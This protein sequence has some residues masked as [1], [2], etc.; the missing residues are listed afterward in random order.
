MASNISPLRSANLLSPRPLTT[1]LRL[2]PSLILVSLFLLCRGPSAAAQ[3]ADSTSA[4]C[5]SVPDSEVITRHAIRNAGLARL[6]DLFHLADRWHTASIDGYTWDAQASGLAPL[7]NPRWT[8]LVDDVPAEIALFGTQSLDA[9]PI[10]INEV[11]CIELIARPHVAAGK[12]QQS[13]SLRILTR[14]PEAGMTLGASVAAGN[15]VNDPGPFAYTPSASP[16]IDRIGP[17][18]TGIIELRSRGRFVRLSGK[19]DEFHVT[20]QQ[21]DLRARQLYSLDSKPRIYTQAFALSAGMETR[22]GTQKI[23]AGRSETDD[24]LFFETFGVEIPAKRRVDMLATSGSLRLRGGE[25][26]YRGSFTS[27]ELLERPNATGINLDFQKRV[28]SAGL[29]SRLGSGPIRTTIG[30]SVDVVDA[31]TSQA[32]QDD[33]TT[34]T[35][36]Y[37]LAEASLADRFHASV[38]GSWIQV[39]DEP[40]VSVMPSVRLMLPGDRWIAASA[41]LARRTLS[42]DPSLWRWTH[43]GYI[44]PDPPSNDDGIRPSGPSA[45]TVANLRRPATPELFTADAEFGGRMPEGVDYLVGAY[46]R[47]SFTDYLADHHIDYSEESTGFLTRTR[48]FDDVSGEIIG[49]HTRLSLSL[50]PGFTQRFT[51]VAE[52]AIAGDSLFERAHARV[53]SQRFA[54]TATFSPNDRFSLWARAR[55]QPSTVWSEYEAASVSSGGF[56]VSELA[57]RVLLDVAATKRLWRDHLA[58]TLSIRNL[59]NEPYRAHPAGAVFN[60]SFHFVLRASF[61]SEAGL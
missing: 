28:I 12:L 30:G 35:R 47:R 32:L 37:G 8:V 20:D 46:Y 38:F 39:E 17:I 26:L 29:D 15:E 52:S 3:P 27:H 5:R 2:P 21:V 48:I 49:F 14:R 7:S 45:G 9:L 36:L 44:L 43:L 13:G 4:S 24:L 11:E 34:I 18:G 10:H 22:W 55:Y 51:Y 61:N 33:R 42:M 6:S 56:Y 40:A 58:A 60:M 31:R 53:P 19:L 50:L 59:L 23:V 25:L 57:A 54:L 41:S 1:L 16:N